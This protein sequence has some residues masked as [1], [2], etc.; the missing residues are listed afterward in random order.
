MEEKQALNFSGIRSAEMLYFVWASTVL[1]LVHITKELVNGSG[2]LYCAGL[3]ALYNPF[4]M[5]I[6]SLYYID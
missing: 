5:L 1:I 3:V 4:R 6:G 2:R